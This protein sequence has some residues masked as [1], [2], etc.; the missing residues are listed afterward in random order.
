MA[1]APSGETIICSVAIRSVAIRIRLSHAPRLGKFRCLIGSGASSPSDVLVD[2][3]ELASES[4]RGG[5]VGG[6]GGWWCW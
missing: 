6:A 1:I 4:I 3:G 2:E 5:A